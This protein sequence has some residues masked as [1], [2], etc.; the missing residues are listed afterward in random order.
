MGLLPIRDSDL[1]VS[2]L[3]LVRA[4]LTSDS[5][6]PPVAPMGA[7]TELRLYGRRSLPPPPSQVRD[8]IR[9]HHWRSEVGTVAF[10]SELSFP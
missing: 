8:L 9:R 6:R 7:T 4:A 3:R 1:V 10:I 2:I 5:T